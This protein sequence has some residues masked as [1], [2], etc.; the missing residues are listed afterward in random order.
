MAATFSHEVRNPL[1]ALR[2]YAEILKEEVAECAPD[3]AAASRQHIRD[4]RDALRRR[5]ITLHLDGV[6]GLGCAL[7]HLSTFRRAI[8]NLLQNAIDAIG[9]GGHLTLRGRETDHGLQLESID[10]GPGI[11]PESISDLPGALRP[12]PCCWRAARA[13]PPTSRA[14]QWRR[15]GLKSAFE[16][17]ILSGKYLFQV[18]CPHDVN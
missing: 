10:T 5:H 9:D 7:L 12:A 16:K 15:G 1:Q 3:T 13:T 2:L 4:Q 18:G 17:P 6:D 14:D 11:A 8:L